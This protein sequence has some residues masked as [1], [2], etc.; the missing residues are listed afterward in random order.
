MTY[1]RL[2]GGGGGGGG[3]LSSRHDELG[4]RSSRE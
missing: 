4:C 2:G 1:G 3:L